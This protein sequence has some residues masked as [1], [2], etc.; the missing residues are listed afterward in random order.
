[1]FTTSTKEKKQRKFRTK[2]IGLEDDETNQES[3]NLSGQ[4]N[5]NNDKTSPSDMST[6]TNKSNDSEKSTILTETISR[7]SQSKKPSLTLLSFNEEVNTFIIEYSFTHLIVHK[8]TY[9]NKILKT[10]Q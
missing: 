2:R 1:M 10:F 6:P 3:E 8:Y 5:P 4:Q 9:K 7:S